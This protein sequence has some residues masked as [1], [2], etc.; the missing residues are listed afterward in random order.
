V[1]NA[2][3]KVQNVKAKA[4][5]DL[6]GILFCISFICYKIEEMTEKEKIF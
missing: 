1:Q 5:E 6:S 3:L 2:K 4:E